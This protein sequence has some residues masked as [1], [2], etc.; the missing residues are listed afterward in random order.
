MKCR[1]CNKET[2]KFVKG[3]DQ[4]GSTFTVCQECANAMLTIKEYGKDFDHCDNCG[5]KEPKEALKTFKK[6]K[7]DIKVCRQCFDQLC[8]FKP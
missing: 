3:T 1:E 8:G 7:E 2:E 6:R 5:A 4:F